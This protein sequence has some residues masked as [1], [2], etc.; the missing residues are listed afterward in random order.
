MLH[1]GWRF[2]TTWSC[3]KLWSGFHNYGRSLWTQNVKPKRTP[4][5]GGF[6]TNL[7]AVPTLRLWWK[8]K[9]SLVVMFL[10]PSSGLITPQEIPLMFIYDRAESTLGQKW[11]QRKCN[12]RPSACSALPKQTASQPTLFP[13]ISHFTF[14]YKPVGIWAY[15]EFYQVRRVRWVNCLH[16]TIT[17]V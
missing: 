13:H 11:P 4:K 8:P 6:V 14:L 16:A 15:R 7:L 17:W 2:G 12:Q 1:N 5:R 9:K 10:A 3:Q